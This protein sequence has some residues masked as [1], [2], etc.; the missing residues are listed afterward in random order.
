M[1]NAAASF[2]DDFDLKEPSRKKAPRRAA[3]GPRKKKGRRRFGFNLDMKQVARYAAIGMSATVAL[4]IM[5]NA[6]VL[7]KSRHPAPLFGTSISMVETNTA[8]TRPAPVKRV[9]P[10]VPATTPMP[11]AKPAE[12]TQAGDNVP[13]ASDDKI[14]LLLQH[15]TMPSDHPDTKTVAGAQRALV[16]L[17]FV[18]KPTGTFGP[19]TKKAL[20]LFEKDRHLPVNGELNRR[21]LKILAAESGLKIEH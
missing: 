4:G 12:A 21:V 16:K 3:P 14:A 13:S 11:V 10:E 9:A 7:Q 20:E 17:G 15:A 5:V 19:Q 1:R 18:L 8:V 6:L 2:D